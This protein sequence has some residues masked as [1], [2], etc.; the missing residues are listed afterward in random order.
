M[1][2]KK[3]TPEELEAL[4]FRSLVDQIN[5][6]FSHTYADVPPQDNDNKIEDIISFIEDNKK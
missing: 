4:S 3:R 5:D 6:K 1:N 2:F